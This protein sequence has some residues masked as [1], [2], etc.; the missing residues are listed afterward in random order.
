MRHNAPMHSA[1]RVL[2]LLGLLLGVVGCGADE[3]VRFRAVRPDKIYRS[4]VSLSPGATEILA[5]NVDVMLLK[6]RT[7]SCNY[8]DSIKGVPVVASVKPN[9]EKIASIKP[10]LLVYD[11]VLYSEADIARLKGVGETFAFK[12]NTLDGFLEELAQLG[13]LTGKET[14]LSGYIDKIVDERS[15]AQGDPITPKPRVVFL[16]AGRGSAHMVLGTGSFLAD[17][18]RASGGEPVGPEADRFVTTD[19]ERLVALNPDV[20]LVADDKQ[21]AG[22]QAIL[23]DP[24]LR[25]VA[26]VK[27]RRV[28]P[29]NADYAVRRGARVDKL[30][31]ALHGALARGRA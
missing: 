15:A 22:T 24:A 12:A 5:Q 23:A 27:S 14:G 10:D 21:G 17:V 11:A 29:I 8:P 20:I 9:Y 2:L 6:G 1:S 16:M 26:A 4:F 31:Q 7:A 13:S 25:A 30:I 18:V 19:P 3:S 28:V